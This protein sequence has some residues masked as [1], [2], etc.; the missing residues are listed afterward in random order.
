MRLPCPSKILVSRRS[1]E[2]SKKLQEEF[3]HLVEVVEDPSDIVA[4]SDIIFIG[5]TNIYVITVVVYIKYP[6]GLLPAVA[7]SLL[8]SI[9]FLG[10][11][12][13][14]LSSHFM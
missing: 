7:R 9:D 11:V 12:K 8:P 14:Y 13:C 5:K 10:T 2:K 1:E 4:R 6:S 3:S